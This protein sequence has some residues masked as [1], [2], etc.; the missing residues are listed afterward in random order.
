MM[1]GIAVLIG[2]LP[3]SAA[4]LSQLLDRAPHRGAD[5]H[6][7]AADRTGALGCTWTGTMTGPYAV[8]ANVSADKL[9]CVADA[10]IDNRAEVAAELLGPR[11]PVPADPELLL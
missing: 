1:T 4:R 11:Q 3:D 9:I 10:R 5:R 8:L 6:V 2:S 7:L